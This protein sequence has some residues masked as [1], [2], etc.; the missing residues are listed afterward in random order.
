MFISYE[1]Y[2]IATKSH[3]S[4]ILPLS[5][6]V[7]IQ[8]EFKYTRIDDYLLENMKESDLAWIEYKD[9]INSH[10]NTSAAPPLTLDEVYVKAQNEW[11]VKRDDVTIYFEADNGGLISSCGY[12]PNG[13]ADDCFR[14]IHIITIQKGD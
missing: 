14:G 6:G 13:C 4:T 11:L 2:S 5:K 9:E 1:I 10:T 3:L 8:R 12:V 7:V